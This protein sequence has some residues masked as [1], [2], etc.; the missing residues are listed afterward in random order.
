MLIISK[1]CPVCGGGIHVTIDKEQNTLTKK[2]VYWS[3][4]FSGD[5]IALA[6]RIVSGMCGS[7]WRYVF[8]IDEQEFLDIFK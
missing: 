2:D 3:T 1:K 4:V 5:D 7:C 8:Q 6:E